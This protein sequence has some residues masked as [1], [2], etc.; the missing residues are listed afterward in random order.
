MD[1]RADTHTCICMA[2]QAEKRKLKN[3]LS[4]ME[5]V[6]INIRCCYFTGC[7]HSN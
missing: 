1:I 4:E 2:L 7:I 6:S 3:H 5:G